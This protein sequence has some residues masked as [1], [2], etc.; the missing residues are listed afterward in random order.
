MQSE[1]I[2]GEAP[3]PSTRRWPRLKINV[4]IRAIVQRDARVLIVQGRGNEL[5]EGGL[6]VFAG[7]ELRVGDNVD[8]EFTP[9]YHGLPVRTRCIVRNRRGYYYGVE[10]RHGTPEDEEKIATIRQT[11]QAMG[12]P[13]Q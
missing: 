11:L 7:V 3:F 6:Q 5:N 10:F 9:P 1:A 4:P 8:I 13:L 2:A 12:S